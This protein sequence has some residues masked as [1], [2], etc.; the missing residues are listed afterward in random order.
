MEK[1][2]VTVIDTEDPE[3]VRQRD[4]IRPEPVGTRPMRETATGTGPGSA[5]YGR[6]ARRVPRGD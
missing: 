5:Y 1:P 2:K 6:R 3:S 4:G